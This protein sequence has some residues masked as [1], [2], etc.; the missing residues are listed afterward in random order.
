MNKL[1]NGTLQY[2]VAN[3]YTGGTAV[4]AGTLA[5]NYSNPIASSV[6]SVLTMQAGGTVIAMGQKV[7]GDNNGATDATTTAVNINGGVFN[8]G[9]SGG[10]VV[11]NI[12][13]NMTGG[14]LGATVSG[15]SIGLYQNAVVNVLPSSA[16]AVINAPIYLSG[17]SN[18]FNV[19]GGSAPGGVDLLVNAPIATAFY[20]TK[21]GNGTMVLASTMRFS[22]ISAPM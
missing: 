10:V 7:L 6:P 12:P 20:S 15:G 8:V 14:T 9:Y 3:S 16:T 2:N 17:I 18:G 5:L 19:V 22:V 21:S 4:M 1:G 11:G 13:I